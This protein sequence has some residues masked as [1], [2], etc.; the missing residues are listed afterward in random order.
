MACAGL[1]E[2]G[3][4][5]EAMGSS[6]QAMVGSLTSWTDQYDEAFLTR[7]TTERPIANAMQT[8]PEDNYL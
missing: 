1:K 7:S 4:K 5:R 8:L 3:G 2:G 6:G